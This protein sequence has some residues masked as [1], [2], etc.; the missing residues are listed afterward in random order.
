MIYSKQ[1]ECIPLLIPQSIVA[2]AEHMGGW[3]SLKRI[4]SIL[5]EPGCAIN[6]LDISD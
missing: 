1:P 4:K 6:K 3:N 5:Y 2:S